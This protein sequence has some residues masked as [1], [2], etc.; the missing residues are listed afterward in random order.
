MTADNEL[1]TG[2]AVLQ[3]D[4]MEFEAVTAINIDEIMPDLLAHDR[5]VTV[6][7]D[8]D[9]HGRETAKAIETRNGTHT[10]AFA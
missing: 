3:E 10:R 4:R 9:Q 8:I 1:H 7:R 2:Q 5:V 6:T